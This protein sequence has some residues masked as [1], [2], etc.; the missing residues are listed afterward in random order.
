MNTKIILL[1]SLLISGM[2][3]S[4]ENSVV[5]NG[6]TNI[7]T[8]KCTNDNFGDS[9]S[10]YSFS[11]NRLPNLVLKVDDFDCR[12]RMMTSDFRKTLNSQSYPNLSIKFL[13]FSKLPGNRFA[14]IVEVKMMTI[15]RKYNIEFSEYKNSLVGN[16]R[17]KFSDFNIVPPKK[18][19]GVIYV[20]DELDLQFSIAVKD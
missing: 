20:K 2:L 7:N 14:A 11:G 13:E 4:Q 8:F 9:N 12:N 10:I 5:I 18:M 3:L 6:W 17:L 1:L 16:K 19:G 15:T